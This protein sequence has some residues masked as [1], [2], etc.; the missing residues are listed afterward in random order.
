M[1]S[2]ER[3][4]KALNHQEP[5]RIPFDLGSTQVTGIAAV[6][7]QNL[8]NYLNME[9]EEIV[10]SDVVQQL[11]LP[12]EKF[13]QRLNVDTRGLFPLTSHNWNIDKKSTHI[14]NGYE[15]TDEWGMV[16]RKPDDGHWYGITYS[17]MAN[18]EPEEQ[19][20]TAHQWPDASNKERVAGVRDKALKYR[21]LDKTVTVKGLCAGV[22]EMSQRL[23]GMENALMDPLLYP[24]FSD[25]LL[26]KI[27]DLKI[28]YWDMVLSELGD[29]VDIVA[30]TDDYG[31]Q[32]SQLVDPKEFRRVYKPHI[33]R[34]ISFIR[35]NAPHA[36]VLFHSCGNIRPIIPD[37]IEMGIQ[38]LNPIHIS[39]TGMDPKQL[40][41]D[42]GDDVVFWGGG[43]ETQ[44]ILPNGS[45]QKI[46]DNV[47][48]NID[49]LAPG[50]GFVF[51]TVHNIQSEV[52]PKNI[53]SMWNTLTEYG[54]Y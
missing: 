12:S 22:F 41:K 39:A 30:E 37:F 43:V 10:F 46:A 50:G 4:L 19:T 48:R 34:L 23:R 18:K 36:F 54:H 42:F 29:V 5:D 35:T 11:S 40:K 15:F 3:I 20:I 45:P 9:E 21:E 44:D 24:E 8:L 31:T 7:Y 47:K 27:I 6:A 1:T 32:I 25:K 26:G 52:S 49:A 28:E 33:S 38:I 2:R 13:L 14:N 53:M 17:P 51:N 16:Q